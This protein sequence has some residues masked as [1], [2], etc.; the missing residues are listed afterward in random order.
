[1]AT[2][3]RRRRTAGMRF[4]PG[5]GFQARSLA[6]RDQ[7]PRLHPAELHALRR[8]RHRSSRRRPTRTQEHLEEAERPLRRGAAKRACSTS[9]RFPARSPRTRPATS[10]ATT[11]SSS[12]CRPMRRSSGRSCRTAASGWSRTRSRPT[13]TSPIR[14]VV[15]TFTKYRKTHNDGGLRCVYGRR[16]ALPQFAHPHR[17]ARCI[18]ARPDHRR[19]PARRRST[20]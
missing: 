19:L 4:R 11:K 13:A 3:Q 15:E 1:M 2:I 7:R 12:A 20:A 16:P 17:P 14:S 9:P 8:R 5:R 18:R 10:T 6:E